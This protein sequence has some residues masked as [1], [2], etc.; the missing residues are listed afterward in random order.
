[1]TRTQ[2]SGHHAGERVELEVIDGCCWRTSL[3]TAWA[4]AEDRHDLVRHHEFVHDDIVIN[5]AVI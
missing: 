3:R 1:V 5:Q 4:D 2:P